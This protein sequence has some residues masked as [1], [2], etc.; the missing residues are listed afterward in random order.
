MAITPQILFRNRALQNYFAEEL[1]IEQWKWDASTFSYIDVDFEQ[2]KYDFEELITSQMIDDLIGRLP[3]VY[4]DKT[5]MELRVNIRQAAIS[6]IAYTIAGNEVFSP[7]GGVG[8]KNFWIEKSKDGVSFKIGEVV[9]AIC[10]R[11]TGSNQREILRLLNDEISLKEVE[12]WLFPGVYDDTQEALESYSA[13]LKNGKEFRDF[14][15]THKIPAFPNE[16][17]VDADSIDQGCTN[18][19][20]F[21]IPPE[22]MNKYKVKQED[23]MTIGVYPYCSTIVRDKL[24]ESVD[25]IQQIVSHQNLPTAIQLNNMKLRAA[26]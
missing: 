5:L 8:P 24:D 4:T 17:Y 12:C 14:E 6:K 22:W 21:R 25:L 19:L 1:L 9:E 18:G 10:S 2:T 13:S 3:D 11:M 16:I 7:T 20:T 26:C 15:K 23:L